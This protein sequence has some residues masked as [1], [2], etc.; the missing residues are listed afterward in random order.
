MDPR[1]LDRCRRQQNVHT[2]L[3]VYS[4]MED[5]TDTRN[6]HCEIH[7]TGTETVWRAEMS[8]GKFEE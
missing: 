1:I 6:V 2:S 3:D 5:E 4:D 8:V 7:K